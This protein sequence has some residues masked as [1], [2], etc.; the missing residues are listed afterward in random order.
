[1]CEEREVQGRLEREVSRK[2]RVKTRDVFVLWCGRIAVGGT[3]TAQWGWT[4]SENHVPCCAYLDSDSNIPINIAPI[5]IYVLRSGSQLL[6][7]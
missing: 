7:C 1:M 6:K 5:R 2:A 3:V 4:K